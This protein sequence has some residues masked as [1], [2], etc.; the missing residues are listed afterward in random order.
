MAAP[1]TLDRL[2]ADLPVAAYTCDRDGLLTGFNPA[3]ARLWGREPALLDPADRFCGAERLYTPAGDP[4]PRD[5]CWVA[6]SLREGR[7]FDARPIRV[8]RTDGGVRD[9]L[10]FA[11]PVRDPAGGLAGGVNLAADVTAGRPTEAA[12]VHA[13]ADLLAAVLDLRRA[14]ADAA[15]PAGGL[16]PV[17]AH[18]KAVRGPAGGWRPVEDHL[19][20]RTGESATHTICPACL[21]LHFGDLLDGRLAATDLSGPPVGG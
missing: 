9:V 20:A 6:R 4:V 12:V 14:L 21:R 7:P 10:V 5:R 18:C 15:R 3:A 19:R 17:C 2:P 8:G 13:L 11:R 1:P 16:V